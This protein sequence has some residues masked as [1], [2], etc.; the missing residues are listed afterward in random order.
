MRIPE[1]SSLRQFAHAVDVRRLSDRQA[2][3]HV[4]G[5]STDALLAAVRA[6]GTDAEDILRHLRRMSAP[7]GA[8]QMA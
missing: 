8:S 6:V 2:W 3:A 4:F 5:V 1:T 7:R